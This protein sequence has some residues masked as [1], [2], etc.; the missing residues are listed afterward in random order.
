MN[1]I[2]ITLLTLGVWIILSVI[3]VLNFV[4]DVSE[5]PFEIALYSFYLT[6]FVCIAA[7]AISLF[8]YRPWIINNRIG[9]AI[10]S[11]ILIV[12]VLYIVL[13]TRLLFS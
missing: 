8:I 2:K 4:E 3:Y 7:F 13:Y 6:P 5:K 10:F 9:F 1:P 12:W 11:L